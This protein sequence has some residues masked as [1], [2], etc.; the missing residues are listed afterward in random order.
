MVGAY[1]RPDG[2][3]WRGDEAPME[4]TATPVDALGVAVLAL[5]LV[6]AAVAGHRRARRDVVAL[7]TLA[8]ALLTAAVPATSRLVTPTEAYLSQWLKVVAALG[9]FAVGWAVWRCAGARLVGSPAE[10]RR[11]ATVAGVVVAV[12]T[13][14]A[15]SSWPGA[16]TMALPS[17]DLAGKLAEVQAGV[18]DELDRGRTYRV[19]FVGEHFVHYTSVLPALDDAGYTVVTDD[20]AAGQKWG[21]RLL[22]EPGDPVD[23]TL[24]VT[25]DSAR[26]PAAEVAACDADP[27]ARLVFAS[28]GLTPGEQAW[29]DDFNWRNL[30]DPGSVTERDMA[31]WHVLTATLDRIRIYEAPRPCAEH[32]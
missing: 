24:T 16:A 7:A 27:D 6:G 30:T 14:A 15:G 4:V 9:W 32:R 22:W 1:A 26:E 29:L 5:L 2:H 8:L 25:I 3:W 31:R 10:P 28:A 21:R 13:L 20:G 17:Q 12:V 23:A 18:A 19:E 11:A